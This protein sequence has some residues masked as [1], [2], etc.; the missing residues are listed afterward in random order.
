MWALQNT[1]VFQTDLKLVFDC[2]RYAD[3]KQQFRSHVL[4]NPEYAS[5]DED[6]YDVIARYTNVLDDNVVAVEH[7]LEGGKVDMCKA[8]KELMAD[9]RTEGRRDMILELLKELGSLSEELIQRI[10][11]ESNLQVLS[12]WNR[13]AACAESVQEFEMKM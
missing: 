6:A 5:L 8:M 1:E 12:G 10:R 7:K 9:E 2:I 11:A 3:D 13:L 4:K